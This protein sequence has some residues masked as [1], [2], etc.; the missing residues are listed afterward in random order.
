MSLRWYGDKVTNK[1]QRQV[2]RNVTDACLVVE[3][4][5]KGLMGR[6]GRTESGEAGEKAQ[7]IN[8]YHSKPGEPPRVQT[9]TLR[10]SITHEIHPI[11]P[12]GRVGTNV[13]YGKF[14]E[15]GTRRMAPRPWLRL[16]LA[17]SR[18]KIKRIMGR[19]IR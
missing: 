10:R 5:A 9:G 8:S 19:K 13:K 16:A 11:L 2:R 15:F 12:I 14:L 7:K 1:F 17:K 18:D 3:S 4:T 6:G